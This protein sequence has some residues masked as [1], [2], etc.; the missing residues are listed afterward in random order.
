[1]LKRSTRRKMAWIWAFHAAF[2]AVLWGSIALTLPATPG[3]ASGLI[4]VLEIFGF[5]VLLPPLFVYA[6]LRVGFWLFPGKRVQPKA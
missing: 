2:Q 3:R 6:Y 1:M 5:G 4:T